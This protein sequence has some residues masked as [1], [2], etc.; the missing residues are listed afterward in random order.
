MSEKSVK[1]PNIILISID[2][3]RADHLSCYG[4]DKKTTPHIDRLAGEGTVFLQNYSTG[5]WTPPGH[6]SMLTGLYVSEHGVYGENRLS[7][8]IPTIAVKLKENNYQTAGFVNNSQVGEMVGFNKGH[9]IFVEVWKGVTP[10]S[11]TERV[12]SGMNR[13]VKRFLGYEDMGAEKTNRLFT[14][15]IENHIDKNRPFYAFLHYIEPHNPLNPPR[16]YKNKYLNHTFKNIDSGKIK[17]VAHNPLICFIENMDLNRE[18]IEVLKLLYDAEIAYTDSKIGEVVDILK[19]NNAYDETMIILTS[20]HGEH[21][22]EHGLWSHTASL[23]NEVLHVPLI[24]KYPQVAEYAKEVKDCTQLVDI[25]PTVMEVA[26]ISQNKYIDTSGTS[27]LFN[28][29]DNIKFHDY[30]FSEWEGRVPY[31][32]KSRIDNQG[33]PAD[34]SRITKK[35]WMVSDGKY[36]FILNEDGSKLL[37][38][39]KNDINEQ[40]NLFDQCKDIADMM[41]QVLNEWRKRSSKQVKGEQQEV[42]EQTKQNL[43][44]LGYM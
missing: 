31:Y 3:L 23:Y 18:E 35:M 2:T 39:V 38:D 40:N 1:K 33:T 7:E 44:A 21:F 37:F 34:L 20:D 29:N 6:A 36:K 43:R 32:I 22:G 28:K 15:W 41:E 17:K 5:V 42:D 27:L 19:R 24:I 9:D 11:I 13:R 25:F 30:V 14:K 8:S 12:V 16:P 10:K 26:G 4:Y